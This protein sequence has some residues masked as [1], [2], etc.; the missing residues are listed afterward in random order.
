MPIAVHVAHF[1]LE[2]LSDGRVLTLVSTFIRFQM[3][4]RY[5]AI[6]K[7]TEYTTGNVT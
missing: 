2:L 1:L 6:L 4:Y 7:I 5:H 3:N